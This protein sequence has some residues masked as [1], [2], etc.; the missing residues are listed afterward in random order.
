MSYDMND[1][2]QRLLEKVLEEYDIKGN[3][4]CI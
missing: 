3:L 2:L 1:S 4:A